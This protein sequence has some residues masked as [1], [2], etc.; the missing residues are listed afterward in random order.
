[1]MMMMM[2]VVVVETFN[3][4]WRIGYVIHKLRNA[5]A[6]TILQVLFEYIGH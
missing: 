4:G 1:M 5:E 3:F 6:P 2:M